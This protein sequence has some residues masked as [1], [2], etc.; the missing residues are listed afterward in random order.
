MSPWHRLLRA[1]YER[2]GYRPWNNAKV[3]RFCEM[4]GCTLRDACAIG[5]LQQLNIIRIYYAKNQWPFYLSLHWERI[6][7]VRM[8]KGPDGVDIMTAKL[9]AQSKAK[10]R[11]AKAAAPVPDP[12]YVPISEFHRWDQQAEWMS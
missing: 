7:R 3:K 11:E 1:E 12:K 2:C 5:G 9:I 4:L 10:E 8:G 6:L